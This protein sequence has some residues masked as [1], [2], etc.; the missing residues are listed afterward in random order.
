MVFNISMGFVAC[1][2]DEQERKQASDYDPAPQLDVATVQHNGTPIT[3]SIWEGRW[4][5][6]GATGSVD[7]DTRRRECCNPQVSRRTEIAGRL[8]RS[9]SRITTTASIPIVSS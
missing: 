2:K 6:S 7:H 8:F 5:A 3:A 4:V 9:G 1:G